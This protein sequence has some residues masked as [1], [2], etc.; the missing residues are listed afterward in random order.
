MSDLSL[1]LRP[2]ACASGGHRGRLEVPGFLAWVPVLALAFLALPATAADRAE[3]VLYVLTPVDIGGV[4]IPMIVPEPKPGLVD[5]GPSSRPGKSFDALRARSPKAYGATSLRIDSSSSAT[6]VLDKV[7]DAD[8]VLAEVFWTLSAQGFANLTA[9]PFIVGPVTVDKLS[10]AAHVPMLAVWDLL[11]FHDNPGLLS[12]AFGLVAGKPM[13]ATDVMKLLQKGDVG[14]R[15]ILSDAMAGTALRP[16]LAILEAIANGAMRDAWKLK[17]DDAL[18]ALSDAS[19]QVQAAALDA[20]IA[21]GIAASVPAKAAL[22]AFVERDSTDAELKLRAVKALSDVGVDKFKDVLLAEK[23]KTGTAAEALDAVAKLAKS[24]QVKL[25]A[26][27]LVAAL[28][29]S[30]AGVREA[31]FQGLVAMKQWELL[32]S[33][34][35]GDQLSAKMREQIAVA[36]VDNGSAAAQDQALV[37]LIEKGTA[38]G[39]IFACQTYGKRGAKTASPQLIEAL[40][41]ERGEVRAVAAEALALLKD[42]RAIVPL[43]DAAAASPRDKEAMM[44][45]AESILASLRLDQVQKLVTSKNTEVRQMAIRALA[46]FAKG[47][48]PNPA[49]VSILQEARKD[50]DLNIK[51]SAVYALARLQDD[52]I[53]RDLATDHKN[54]PDAEVRVQVA[55]A[56][57]NASAKLTEADQFLVEM[58]GDRDKK[59]RIEAIGGLAKRKVVAAV[60]A[61]VP[62]AKQPDPD[63]RRAVFA[64]LLALRTPENQAAS[65][66]IFRKGMETQDSALRITCIAALADKTTKED[67]DFLRQAVFD[68]GKEVKLAA[69]AALRASALVEAMDVLSNFFGDEDMAV[70]EQ[71]LEALGSI[72]HG[73]ASKQKNRYLQDF[74]DTPDMPEGLKKKAAALKV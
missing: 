23:L 27:T 43:A 25:A 32:H 3:A 74:I 61:L 59:V 28:S 22:E 4:S 63:V 7:A 55:I 47:S 26:Q 60:P 48:R 51:R 44:V 2:H 67:L 64:A 62:L 10:Y 15:K 13:P 49:V 53:A 54:D 40:K 16:K 31:A 39:A 11:R 24:A 50:P 45:A 46:T 73:A 69:I 72:P 42:E 58:M 33:A 52:G 17:A 19:L 9:P 8:Q 36:L 29:H 21:A 34:M 56:L 66:E 1:A 65:R 14:V 5:S 68:K 41:H 70:L 20:V 35:G 38:Q 6:L 57:A 71:A 37:Y 18:P 12:Q 30:D